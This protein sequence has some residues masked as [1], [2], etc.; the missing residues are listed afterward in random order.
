MRGAFLQLLI[1]NT[2]KVASHWFLTHFCHYSAVYMGGWLGYIKT[3]NELQRNN[4]TQSPDKITTL[5]KYD[6]EVKRFKFLLISWHSE[7]S[8]EDQENTHLGKSPKSNFSDN[9]EREMWDLQWNLSGRNILCICLLQQIC[10]GR[11]RRLLIV[12]WMG[13]WQ[14][15]KLSDR[16]QGPVKT[17]IRKTAWATKDVCKWVSKRQTRRQY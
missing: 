11:A 4:N 13:K 6:T 15:W 10:E 2:A 5:Y 8:T 17:N 9:E 16:R 12:A 7:W 14:C 3:M 1:N